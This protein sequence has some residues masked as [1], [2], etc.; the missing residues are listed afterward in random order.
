MSLHIQLTSGRGGVGL[1]S[2]LLELGGVGGGVVRLVGGATGG[3][4]ARA[5][6]PAVERK[7]PEIGDKSKHVQICQSLKT[8]LGLKFAPGVHTYPR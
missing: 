8:E 1:T 7:D 2:G 4:P 3:L 5:P 6:A